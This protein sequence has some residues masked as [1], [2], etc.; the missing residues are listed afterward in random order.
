MAG[1]LRK[2]KQWCN[3]ASPGEKVKRILTDTR[4]AG[5]DSF[6]IGGSAPIA[7]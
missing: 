4:S 7:M 3:T 5:R 1:S 2:E 6:W